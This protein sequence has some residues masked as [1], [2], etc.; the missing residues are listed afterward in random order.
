MRLEPGTY[1]VRSER[2]TFGQ[3]VALDS[4][5]FSLM[6]VSGE[7]TV[8]ARGGC[9]LF[10]PGRLGNQRPFA[11]I[12]GIGGVEEALE[13]DRVVWIRGTLSGFRSCGSFGSRPAI[14]VDETQIRPGTSRDYYADTVD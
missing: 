7:G 4:G 1:V 3:I 13:T 2:Q 14:R 6:R 12:G 11:L 5:S 10:G 9:T 8:R